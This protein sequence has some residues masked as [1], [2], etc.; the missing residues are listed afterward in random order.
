MDYT[1]T[2]AKPRSIVRRLAPWTAALGL[3]AGGGYG[4]HYY[5][6]SQSGG[7]GDAA[8][9]A[10][11]AANDQSPTDRLLA[12]M[13][14]GR[15]QADALPRYTTPFDPPASR[16]ASAAPT[17]PPTPEDDEVAIPRSAESVEPPVNPFAAAPA[18]DLASGYA[19]VLP[20][21]EPEDN[22]AASRV[23]PPIVDAGE[24]SPGAETASATETPASDVPE[25]AASTGSAIADV[26][27]GQEPGANPLRSG[28]RTPVVTLPVGFAAEP[29]VAEEAA[30]ASSVAAGARTVFEAADATLPPYAA[31]STGETSGASASTNPTP[32]GAGLVTVRD[33][34]AGAIAA[35]DP[36]VAAEPAAANP[37]DA[38]SP[39]PQS[40]AAPLRAAAPAAVETVPSYAAAPP[41][42]DSARLTA[43]ASPPTLAEAPSPY[44]ASLAASP[45]PTPGFDAVAGAGRP[46]E[47]TLEGVQSPALSLQKLAPGEIQ[48]GKPCMFQVRVQNA[49]QRT[50]HNVQ[51]IDEVP[52][53]TQLIGTAPKALVAAGKLTWDLGTLSPGEERIVEMELL[54]VEEG[55]IGS[56]ATVSFASQASVKTRSTRPQLELRLSAAP[57]VMIGEA[58]NV[59]IELTNPG[60]GDATGV[61][62]LE[63]IPEGV[64]H[65]A[66]AALEFEVGTLRAGETKRMDLVLTAAAAGLVDN[67]MTARADANL[68][69]QANCQFEV[70]AP[71][72]RLSVAGP[73]KRI[74]ERP[75]TF[76]MSVDN[77]GTASARD[78]QLVTQLPPGLKFVSANNHGEYDAATHSVYW[79]LPEL[80]ANEH[81]DVELTALAVEAGDHTLQ[82]ATRAQ[83]GLED[84]AET[85]LSVEG[86]VAL[87]FEV[88]DVQDAIEVGGETAYEIRVV[89]QGTKTATNVQVVATMPAGL[90]AQMVQGDARYAIEGDRVVFAPLPQL[91]PKAEAAFRFGV[92]GLGAGDQRVTLQLTTDEVREPIVEVEST[93]VY[94]D[95]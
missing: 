73:A 40:V 54:P 71:E 9:T 34:Q 67:I 32:T 61:M 87:A 46:G 79:S 52:L 78:V 60:S 91:A 45:T 95:E 56:V 26:A 37:T 27:R 51:V 59:Q 22:V 92:Q 4:V 47:L 31:R 65:E 39:L 86:I 81:G 88:Q 10:T 38:A 21:E 14:A 53:G 74:L 48:V 90:R 84:R 13:P 2:P 6:A 42:A 76:K 7:S 77:P 55:E 23:A 70:I 72:L 24:T 49:S 18:G 36:Y 8:S 63:N 16:Y 30:P 58:Q 15:E 17:L 41:A 64:T 25:T 3:F 43:V 11:N 66:G 35:S 94:A 33:A 89:N 85:R 29:V 44:D 57:R 12:A 82:V 93:Q 83:Q 5:A 20:R 19:P 69:V 62:L 68:Q 50:I 75:A 28:S 80:P 1:L